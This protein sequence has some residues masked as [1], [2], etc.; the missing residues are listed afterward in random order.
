MPAYEEPLPTADP[1]AEWIEQIL[2]TSDTYPAATRLARVISQVRKKKGLPFMLDTTKPDT[3]PGRLGFFEPGTGNLHIN[4][5]QITPRS[6][7]GG[8]EIGFLGTTG[9]ELGHG[10]QNLPLLSLLQKYKLAQPA[11]VNNEDFAD[12]A[13]NRFRSQF[14]PAHTKYYT[15]LTNKIL[16]AYIELMFKGQ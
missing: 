14:S 3:N 12:F 13:S 5:K 8:T 16:E 4:P 6:N 15:E 1:L 2:R 10:F 11:G 9:H 7:R